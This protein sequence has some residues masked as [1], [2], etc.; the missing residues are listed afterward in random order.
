MEA[1]KYSRRCARVR[2]SF[3]ARSKV[4]QVV[5]LPVVA[6]DNAMG[7]NRPS[8]MGLHTDFPRCVVATLGRGTTTTL[9][10]APSITK[11]RCVTQRREY[12]SASLY[13]SNMYHN[14]SGRYADLT[15][16]FCRHVA[17]GVS[18]H[19]GILI[20]MASGLSRALSRATREERMTASE[21]RIKTTILSLWR[22]PEHAGMAE[23][24]LGGD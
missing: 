18:C 11:N 1:L 5:V 7:E 12:F 10:A 17:A 16:C 19:P 24:I 23:G 6:C 14:A 20:V 3:V 2:F 21:K 9:R 13:Q 4:P 15:L 8:P 22:G